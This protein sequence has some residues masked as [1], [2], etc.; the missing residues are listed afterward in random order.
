MLVKD[1]LEKGG[2]TVTK[3]DGI[4]DLHHGCLQM[5]RQQDVLLLGIGNLSLKELT[6]SFLAHER[7]INNFTS[8]EST[9][10]LHCGGFAIG[11]GKLN[12]HSGCIRHASRLLTG[13]KIST[14]H[15]RHMRL[16]SSAPATHF[17]GVLHGV[18]LHRACHA[19]VRVTLSQDGVHSR[20]KD[21]SVGIGNGLLLSSRGRGRVQRDIISL[22]SQ[23]GNSII[24]LGNGSRHI[25]KLDNIGIRSQSQL[26]EHGKVV[27]NALRLGQLLGE[28]RQDSS[29]QR[30]ISLLNEDTSLLGKLVDNGQQRICGKGRCL[31]SFSVDDFLHN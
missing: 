24:E 16:R 5:E 18:L 20:T 13:K 21:L 6:Q 17:V 28:M 26:A 29:G 2:D 10:L 31:I 30:D 7:S 4:R 23:L 3:H 8:L 25:R 27:R 19:T 1:R 15:V 22:S 9:A 14:R 11:T 12:L